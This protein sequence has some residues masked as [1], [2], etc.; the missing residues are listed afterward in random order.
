MTNIDYE[1]VDELSIDE[2]YKCFICSKPLKHPVTT[3]CDH[4]YCQDCIQNWLNQN[5]S[6]CPTCHRSVSVNDL[7]PITTRLILNILDKLLVKCP[8]C[9]LSGI[10]RG[11]F[12]DHITR[13][14]PKSI[15]TCTASDI[16]CPW[17]G[18]R[19]ELK[20]HLLTCH[21]E[22]LRPI[23]SQIIDTNKLF[24]EKVSTLTNHVQTLQLAGKTELNINFSM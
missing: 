9:T 20:D 12:T 4:S 18:T 6:S 10:Q 16:K 1:Y 8:Q 21:Y 5:H 3:P 2:N 15:L 24:E 14:C 13:F 22:R 7:T 17:S 11:N 19:V 23:L